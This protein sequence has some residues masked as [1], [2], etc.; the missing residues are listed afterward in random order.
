MIPL[1]RQP[2]AWAK[3]SKIEDAVIRADNKPRRWLTRMA[4]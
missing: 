3:T 2:M 4:E 1:H